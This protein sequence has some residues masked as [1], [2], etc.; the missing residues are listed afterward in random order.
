ME[1]FRALHSVSK[2]ATQA[3][4]WALLSLPSLSSL[5][6]AQNYP[7]FVKEF[8]R[9]PIG[10]LTAV[11]G[12][13]FFIA[14]TGTIGL[15]LWKS[16]GTAAGTVLV[17]D[18]WP[19][20]FSSSPSSLVDLGGTLFFEARDSTAGSELWKSD[21]TEAGTVLVKDILPGPAGSSPIYL[22]VL[23]GT[24]FFRA[25][26]GLWKSDGTEAGTVLVKDI[27]ICCPP[28]VDFGG[29]LFFYA[30]GSE[31]WKSDG[32]TAG[33]VLVKDISPANSISKLTPAGGMLF[34]RAVEATTGE[35]L[36]KSD[37]TAAGTTLLK[38]IWPGTFQSNLSSL[39]EFDGV[40]FFAADDGKIGKELWKSDGTVAG[41][42]LLKE[43]APGTS[44]SD[45][46]WLLDIDGTLFFRA[47]N[48]TAGAELWKSDGTA[49]GTVPV[50]DIWPGTEWSGP[51]GL[52]ALGSTLFFAANDGFAG[53]ELWQSD[54]TESGTV[55]ARDIRL[56][57]WSNPY[58]LTAVDTTLFLVAFGRTSTV[59][60][61]WKTV[62]APVISI[63]NPILVFESTTV[64]D[65]SFTD[66]EI[67]N[68]GL[69]TL[70]I[71]DAQ[72]P[73]GD[74]RVGFSVPFDIAPGEINAVRFFLE[75]EA[76]QSSWADMVLTT[77]DPRTPSTAVSVEGLALELEIEKTRVVPT[78]EQ[79]PLGEKII[80]LVQPGPEVTIEQGYLFH[81]PSDATM[82]DSIPL[83]ET[84][85]ADFQAIIEGKFVTELGLEYF[86]R[87]ENSGFVT[88]D[89]PNA[90]ID[91]FTQAVE[92]PSTL[93][94][95]T[96]PNSP[97]GA[98][99]QGVEIEVEVELPPGSVFSDATLYYRAGGAS[100]YQEITDFSF[101]STSQ[102]ERQWYVAE[103]PG[104][105]VG[106]RGLE[107][108]IE[109]NTVGTTITEP[110]GSPSER[111]NTL[112]VT[113]QNLTEPDPH[114][115]LVYRMIS[116][117]LDFGDFV[118][119][120][121][122]ILS[123]QPEF[124]SYDPTV[125]RS[126]VYMPGI[127]EYAELSDDSHKD[128]FRPQPGR[129]LWLIS[130]SEHVVDTSP[131][132]GV[133]TPT[134]QPSN[135][136]QP[137]PSAPVDAF[138]YDVILQS[139]YN[140]VGNPYN[141]AIAWNSLFA[142]FQP[143]GDVTGGTIE[144]P[145]RWTGSR[146]VSD[147]STL[148]PFEGYWIKNLTGSPMVLSFPSREFAP[149]SNTSN[150]TDVIEHA[151]GDGWTITIATHSTGVEDTENVAGVAEG[152]SDT[153][154]RFDR[155][156][157]PMSPGDG[158][159][160]YFHN[161][162]WKDQAGNYSVDLREGDDGQVWRFDVAKSFSRQSGGDVVTLTFTGIEFVPP[163][164]KA[165]LIDRVLGRE[166]DLREQGAYEFFLATKAVVKHSTPTRF[167][168]IVGGDAFVEENLRE[169][170]ALPIATMLHQNHP[171]PF[172]PSTIVPYEL[173][174]PAHVSLRVYDV[175][176]ALVRVLDEGNYPAG[177][178]EVGWNGDN[179][180]GDRVAS[181][182]Y[183]YHLTASGFS[184]TRKMVL[185]K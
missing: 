141:F 183:F 70:T 169:L 108:W 79:V 55:L 41:T 179:E 124:N 111:P 88:T 96:N 144:P 126:Y 153:R 178:Y 31:I 50:K 129:G 38:D 133:S 123:D 94:V 85:Q 19:G 117:P 24:L 89:P 100:I 2:I 131:V 120:I 136:P 118:G 14:D 109:V 61:L 66:L 74:I 92:S 62:P 138:R 48:A 86:V 185:L 99:L 49:A 73:P 171:N 173:A 134:R 103:I 10:A 68:V 78:A 71:L 87:V 77:N 172:N 107:L 23:G 12:T 7:V 51:N 75:P 139:G 122:A 105:A 42:A 135:V 67:S 161:W 29:T 21:G 54:G 16:D 177:R 142:D 175:N 125:W 157:P 130:K 82:F 176:G 33:T 45:P 167:S 53:Y 83:L 166:I 26:G 137:P 18:I 150:S 147:V 36:W 17:K 93:N 69:D 35:E 56:N 64:G 43:I 143:V 47:G 106:S 81:R 4:F 158:L 28:L 156:E 152:S 58:D 22:T 1:R 97:G 174:S 8:P 80:V 112:G 52:T 115:G 90:P 168:L 37:G 181:G 182:V 121:E 57:G 101:I 154:D 13:L 3:G 9:D 110:A 128:L 114:P 76:G 59:S 151:P 15:E 27:F 132:P 84:S 163:G 160:L 5:A 146:Y 164:Q 155:Y 127:G 104:S 149:V 65:T 91:F 148:E 184:Q 159:S 25:N 32:S 98:F 116:I 20:A 40:L 46:S 119:T 60:Q 113:V 102:P 34:F 39:T 11:G 6:F 170:P 95:T 72:V 165:V 162:E 30:N 44:S 180:R 145:V 140:Q 63:A